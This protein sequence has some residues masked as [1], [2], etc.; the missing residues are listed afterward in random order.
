MLT[1]AR[2]SPLSQAQIQEVQRELAGFFP[3]ICLEPL[4]VQSR[5]D[6]DLKTSLRD[7]PKNDFFTK[8]VDDLL[9]QGKCRIAIHSAKDLPEN[10]PEG[11]QIIALT[12]GQDPKDVLVLRQGVS[13]DS[14]PSGAKIATSSERREKCVRS[15]RSDLTF[16]DLR[17][18]I[19]MRL[20]KLQTGEADGIVVA[21]AALIRLGLTHLN[22]IDV[23]GST[24][25]L[26]GQLA[27]V[28]RK[29]DQEV[30]ALFA[31][32][33]TR[34]H[35]LHVGLRAPKTDHSLR[36][37]HFP[38]IQCVPRLEDRE[39]FRNIPKAT[40]FVFG[41][42]VAVELFFE[43]C[44]SMSIE[45][46]SKIALA[47]GSATATLLRSKGFSNVLVAPQEQTEG[48]LAL[49]D[50]LT[51]EYVFWA[52]SALSRPLIKTYLERRKIPHT[53]CIL[54]DTVLLKTPPNLEGVDEVFFS[55][56]STVDAFAELFPQFPT[57]LK[58]KCI[59]PITEARFE[60]RFS[61]KSKGF[62]LCGCG[63]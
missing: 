39:S 54:Y 35:V 21:E 43:Y 7:L 22:R 16:L 38:L 14:L 62:R 31:K 46:N 53:S 55:S 10:L 4:L 18:T 63:V 17:G 59:G 57:H 60:R 26:Q 5:G 41:S 23:P 49:M 12:K 40:H 48:L 25:P 37:S 19:G 8:E 2:A 13:F 33:D 61:S 27:I 42:Q 3:E 45:W 56:P 1:G 32:L 29:D 52:H 47:V 15:L 6:K 9:L 36:Q 44:N 28:A 30:Q 58:A 20:E 34:K 50:N 11:V 24:T 51:P